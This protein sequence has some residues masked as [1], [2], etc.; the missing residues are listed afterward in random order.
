M[1]FRLHS[2]HDQRSPYELSRTAFA[3]LHTRPAHFGWSWR[4][5]N[6]Q[7]MYRSDSDLSFLGKNCVSIQYTKYIDI[8]AFCSTATNA[9]TAQ[10]RLQCQKVMNR[11]E[12]GPD[13]IWHD[14]NKHLMS[15]NNRE[16]KVSEERKT[17][18]RYHVFN[19]DPLN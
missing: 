6:Q 19:N 15:Q 16:N 13:L 8:I 10:W 1:S 4:S 5:H 17:K 9:H 14:I 11:S 2:G 18:K 3:I 7:V 12:S